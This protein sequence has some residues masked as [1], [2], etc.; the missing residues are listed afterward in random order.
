MIR[1]PGYVEERTL[2]EDTSFFIYEKNLDT[3]LAVTNYSVQSYKYNDKLLLCSRESASSSSPSTINIFK[4]DVL[5]QGFT[6][7]RSL[8]VSTFN[9]KYIVAKDGIDQ[10]L[11]M[12]LSGE[13]L[14]KYNNF[15][16]STAC[17]TEQYIFILDV[18]GVIHK[19]NN[20]TFQE[21]D[22][23]NISIVNGKYKSIKYF[24]NNLYIIY[25]EYYGGLSK[26]LTININLDIIT[27]ITNEIGTYDYIENVKTFSPYIVIST[28][29]GDNNVKT[30]YDA[31]YNKV[32]TIIENY[33]FTNFAFNTDYIVTSSPTILRVYTIQGTLLKEIIT[34]DTIYS[35]SLEL[36]NL[37][38]LYYVNT[39]E[40]VKKYNLLDYSKV[41]ID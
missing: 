24:E 20:T 12:N 2:I 41:Y 15:T 4:N 10:T 34:N 19:I 18:T 8:F 17:I 30:I 3:N 16:I 25:F 40:E 39:Q 13:V 35:N 14:K 32:N 26:Y 6:H 7:T 28:N 31:S 11:I 29:T 37:T 22:T 21:E 33:T 38:D 27:N 1:V 36:I 23:L 9:E 5:T